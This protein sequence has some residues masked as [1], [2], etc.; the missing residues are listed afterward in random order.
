MDLIC[1]MGG[2]GQAE[3]GFHDLM[4][5]HARD[6]DGHMHRPSVVEPDYSSDCRK[7]SILSRTLPFFVSIPSSLSEACLTFF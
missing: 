7:T 3:E 4:I 5:S 2:K 6:S 1:F